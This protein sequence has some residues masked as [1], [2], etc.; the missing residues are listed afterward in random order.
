[1]IFN[2]T[3]PGWKWTAGGEQG[4]RAYA[5]NSF[6]WREII[7]GPLKRT[8]AQ[9]CSISRPSHAPTGGGWCRRP[10]CFLG[11]TGECESARGIASWNG[12]APRSPF[13]SSAIPYS[14]IGVHWDDRNL[15]MPLTCAAKRQETYSSVGVQIVTIQGPK[16]GK[17]V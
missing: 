1:M 11:S 8:P 12:Q 15:R 13:V 7:H 2:E 16:P 3:S 14:P 9:S 4:V 5:G 17:W 10:F 6:Q